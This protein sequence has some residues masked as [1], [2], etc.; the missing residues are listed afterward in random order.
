[1]DYALLKVGDAASI[2]TQVEITKW[3]GKVVVSCLY[4]PLE[5]C[6][7]YRLIF[8]DCHEITMRVINPESR[9]DATADLIGFSIGEECHHTPA[10]ITTDI[11][12]ISI[13]YGSFL[14]QKDC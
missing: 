1:M 11:F 10:V 14:V 2:V 8:E 4:D 3:G 5:S 7:P 13:L 12:E 9:Q 6:R